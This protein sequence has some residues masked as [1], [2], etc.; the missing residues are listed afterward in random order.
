MADQVWLPA[1]YVFN[2][3]FR[4]SMDVFP[5]EGFIGIAHVGFLF[6]RESRML[7]ASCDLDSLKSVDAPFLTMFLKFNEVVKSGI[8]RVHGHYNLSPQVRKKRLEFE[9]KSYFVHSKLCVESVEFKLRLTCDEA[10]VSRN[11]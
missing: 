10:P 11:M 2:K 7:A 1:F 4:V 5:F 3:G 6:E 9:G 8:K